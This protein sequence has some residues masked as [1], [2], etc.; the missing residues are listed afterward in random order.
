MIPPTVEELIKKRTRCLIS[1][2]KAI[3]KYPGQYFEINNLLKHI[4]SE[5]IDISE[6]YGLACNLAKLLA[7]M[8]IGTI[9]YEYFHD[10]INPKQSGN[11]RYFRFVCRDLLDQIKDLNRW[12]INKRKMF[13]I[14]GSRR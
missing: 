4:I 13:L 11:I 1:S 10:N 2:E 3:S 12:R 9:F 5:K 14:K 7:K 6:Y 8:G